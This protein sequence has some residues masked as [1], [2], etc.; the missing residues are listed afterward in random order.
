MH[1]RIFQCNLFSFKRNS[2]QGLHWCCGFLVLEELKAFH[3]ISCQQ[4]V[5]HTCICALIYAQ[6]ECHPY[7]GL[8]IWPK[9]FLEFELCPTYTK[10]LETSQNFLG[11]AS[12]VNTNSR[13]FYSNFIQAFSCQP[14]S[15]I[16]TKKS[17]WVDV[18]TQWKVLQ[19]IHLKQLEVCIILVQNGKRDR[20]SYKHLRLKEGK[21]FQDTMHP[22]IYIHHHIVNITLDTKILPVLHLKTHETHAPSPYQTGKTS[23]CQESV[24]RSNFETFQEQNSWKIFYI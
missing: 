17:G 18:R 13:Y 1:E 19:E 16:S 11:W 22:S 20:M 7:L 14:T 15:D 21:N 2:T 12:C 9:D 24:C 5:I 10:L 8:S 3:A 6:R 23:C 4:L